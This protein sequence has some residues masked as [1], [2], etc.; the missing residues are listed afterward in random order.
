M[1]MTHNFQFQIVALKALLQTKGDLHTDIDVCLISPSSQVCNLDV[2]LDSTL[3]FCVHVK[4]V[5]KSIFPPKEHLL[6][7]AM[8][9]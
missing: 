6:T 2:I 9:H 3:A 5:T 8:T 7:S 1:L 4:S